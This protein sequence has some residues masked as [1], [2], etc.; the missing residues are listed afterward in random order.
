LPSGAIRR[1]RFIDKD[2]SATINIRIAKDK[3][4]FDNNAWLL[5]V[6][7][8]PVDVEL[9][10]KNEN[11]KRVI[12]RAVFATGL[13]R[14][15]SS[16]TQ[17]LITDSKDSVP[18]EEG[19]WHLYLHVASQPSAISGVI[20]VDKEHPLVTGFPPVKA[21]W[22]IDP[23][24]TAVGKPLMSAAT[25]SL[26]SVEGDPEQRVAINMNMTPDYSDL[27]KSPI[28]PVMF[29]NLMNWRQQFFPGPLDANFRSGNQIKLALPAGEKA[30]TMLDPAGKKIEEASVWRNQAVFQS[31]LPGLFQ[32]KT[33]IASWPVAVNLCSPA[34]SDLSGAS[35]LPPPAMPFAEDAM[36]QFADV[37]WWFLLPAMLLIALHQWLSCRRRP[38]DAAR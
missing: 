15:S 36:L 1:I 20:A 3:V 22:A 8:R 26:L 14:I 21:A 38:A 16:S 23:E 37:R 12:E 17:L 2:T 10:L 29:W 4:E 5:P 32:I 31:S 35:S 24:F 27:H 28:W 25:T 34:E 7:L 19:L 11:F 9:R 33:E 30:A 13:A 18:A 6:R